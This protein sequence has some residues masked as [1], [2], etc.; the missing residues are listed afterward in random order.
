MEYFLFF[1]HFTFFNVRTYRVNI[2]RKHIHSKFKQNALLPF[3]S[4]PF[5][6][7]PCTFLA[8]RSPQHASFLYFLPPF[9][10]YLSFSLASEVKCSSVSTIDFEIG[11]CNKKQTRADARGIIQAAV[12]SSSMIPFVFS[13]VSRRP[14][15]S[16][17]N[18]RPFRDC[19]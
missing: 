4:L 12:S 2:N 11:C 16:L 15:L 19:A 10:P 8:P 6:S 1:S 9:F 17:V 3:L 5:S 18:A 7:H 14:F 13:R